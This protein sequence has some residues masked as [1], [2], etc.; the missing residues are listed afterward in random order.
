M[1]L[2]SLIA[3]GVSGATVCDP[4]ASTSLWPFDVHVAKWYS[5]NS[6]NGKTND[7]GHTPEMCN[8]EPNSVRIQVRPNLAECLVAHAGACKIPMHDFVS[9]DFDFHMDRC[10]GIWAAPMWMTPDVWQWG[11]G[12]GEIDSMEMCPRDSIHL[13]FAGGGHQVSTDWDPN[14]AEGHVT[15]RKDA[16]GIVTIAHCSF[17]EANANG[18]Q[19]KAPVYS[20]C[21][22][23]M[24]GSNSFACWCNEPDNI[25]GSGGCVNGGNCMWTLVSDI[26]NG[27]WGDDGFNGCM[28]AVPSIGL[29]AKQ[30]NL[31]SNCKFSVEKV[32]LRGNNGPLQ[33]GPGSPESCMVL[34]TSTL[35][36]ATNV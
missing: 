8:G 12:S 27:I 5:C 22:D 15:T 10:N 32:T 30:P 16:R 28:T 4:S 26:W 24:K 14:N 6:A 20:S 23:C 3:V 1:F 29:A 19:C 34:T 21:T 13:N 7:M 33:F 25:Y 9:L 31:N 2:L 17:Q 35:A 18:G 11:G 36:N